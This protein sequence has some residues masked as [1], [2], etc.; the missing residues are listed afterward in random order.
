MFQIGTHVLHYRIIGPLGSGGM[1]L[2]FRAE[3][4]RL[5]REVALKFLREDVAT[6]PEQRKRL[7]REARAASA[8]RSPGIASIY[9]VGEVDGQMF[10]VMELVEGEPLSVL[11]ASGPLPVRQAVD[12]AAQVAD[13]LDAA[14]AAGV[15]HR[16]IKPANLLVDARGRVKVLDFG[17]AKRLRARDQ[18]MERTRQQSLQTRAGSLLGTFSYMSPEQAMGRDVDHRSD[19]FSLGVVLFEML[20]GR[21]PFDGASAMETLSRVV[22][23][24]PPALARFNHAVPPALDHVVAKALAKDP[25][26][27]HQSAREFYVDLVAIARQID[28]GSSAARSNGLGPRLSWAAEGLPAAERPERGV[29]VLTFANLRGE[30]AD[31][32]IGSG[33]AETVTA[34]LQNVKGITVIGRAQVSDAARDAA[35]GGSSNGGDPPGLE[36]GRRIGATWIVTGAFQRVGDVVRITAEFVGVATGAVLRT[37]KVDGRFDQ[38]FDLQDRIV[39]ELSKG[40][41]LAL[42][43]A[44]IGRIERDETRSVEAYESY[45]RGTIN[46]R[47]G[48]RDS[49]DRAVAFFERALARDPDYAE[50][51]MALGMALD[52]KG[53]FLSLPELSGRAIDALQR[54]VAG[55]PALALAH[56][57]LGSA[58]L[59]LRRHDEALAA[60]REALRLDPS[61]SPA[62]A[63]LGRI[64][65]FGLGQFEDGIRELEIAASLNVEGGYAF[66]QLSLLYALTNDYRKAELAARRAIDLQ[67]R[68]V[69][70]REGLQIVSAHLRLGYA[71]YRQERYEEAIAEYERELSFVSS[72]DHALRER[73]LIEAHQKLAAAYWRRGDRAA[74]DREFDRAR[75]RFVTRLATGA[76]DGA[77]KYYVAAMY[78]LRGEAEPAGRYL[79]EAI[80]QLPGL[81]RARARVD[82]DF[83]PVRTDSRVAALIAG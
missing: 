58:Y 39:F 30:P 76:D 53:E 72:G 34:D 61:L 13:A 3:D 21:R 49:L 52:L 45:S 31:E 75:V 24:P 80:E 55:N 19:L 8:L 51:W 27:R 50:A 38:I 32:W 67:E 11:L 18:D 60:V 59:S 82:P 1:G 29:A 15:V 5:R 33:I 41:D 48:T 25:A 26:F 63:M 4:V 43:E 77:T 17:L 14:H 7:M 23:D 9:D 40:L 83:D 73:T 54:A 71:F 35:A 2:V 62:H 56:A 79:A 22:N 68:Y 57:H 74:A 37:V 69:S 6:D 66:L 42:D 10:L 20:T 47:M 64:H 36:I 70:G 12:V 44:A 16:D 28:S 78:G 46:L 81:N 65:W